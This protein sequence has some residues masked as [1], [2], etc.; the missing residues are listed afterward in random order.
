MT[1]VTHCKVEEAEAGTRLD[2]WFQKRFPSVTHGRL[3]KLLRTGQVRVD[4][5]RAK[6]SLRLEAGQE[7]RVPPLGDSEPQSGSAKPRPERKVTAADEAFICSRVL[8]MD[9]DVIAIDKPAGLAVQGGSGTNRHLDGMLDALRFGASERPRLVHRLD[10][11]TSGVMLLARTASAAA[12]LGE[13]FQR[14]D[15]RKIYWALTVGVPA[16][17]SGRIDISLGKR[18]GRGGEKMEPDDDEGKRAVTLYTVIEKVGKRL[19]WLALWPQ[20]GRTHQLR[21][22]CVAIGC[23]ILG[24][25]KYGGGAAFVDGLPSGAKKLQ[26]HAR[27]ITVPHPSGRGVFHAVA[28]LPPH[29]AEV[30]KMLGLGRPPTD[31]PFAA[32]A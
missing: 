27:E 1:G 21:A 28:D 4:G 10:R 17:E 32:I 20:T 5:K 18:P 3:Q 7:I 25:G 30:W 19:A 22:H 26:L 23:P 16:I 9:D 29:M 13:A 6:A 14:R 2:R 11:D 8:T 15:T 24:D 12:R 31:D